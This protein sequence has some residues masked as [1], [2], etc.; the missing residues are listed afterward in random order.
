MDNI[1]LSTV[2]DSLYR[3]QKI[4]KISK[5]LKKEKQTLKNERNWM[6]RNNQRRLYE[7]WSTADAAAAATVAT[8]QRN[9]RDFK[10]KKVDG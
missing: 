4:Q 8:R 6:F 5:Q 1:N 3:L 7:L 2:S 10:R 9:W